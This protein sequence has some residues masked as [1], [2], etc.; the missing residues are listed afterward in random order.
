MIGF[1]KYWNFPNCLCTIDGN[2]ITENIYSGFGYFN[3]KG[4]SIVLQSVTPNLYLLRLMILNVIVME[5][6]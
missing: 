2:H 1:E 4:H 3:Y 6:F 5:V